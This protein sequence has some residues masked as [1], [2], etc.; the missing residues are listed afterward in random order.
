MVKSSRRVLQHARFSRVGQTGEVGLRIRSIAFKATEAYSTLL[1]M[2]CLCGMTDFPP[3]RRV[4]D[5]DGRTSTFSAWV[6]HISGS[7]QLECNSITDLTRYQDLKFL[8]M[9]LVFC[10]PSYRHA[11]ERVNLLND[12]SSCCQFQAMKL[13]RNRASFPPR[14]RSPMPNQHRN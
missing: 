6:V 13:L 7:T 2:R 4:V 10:L 12:I 11:R 8:C 3:S 14:S 5:T 1:P 9:C